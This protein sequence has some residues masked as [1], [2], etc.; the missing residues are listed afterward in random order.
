MGGGLANKVARAIQDHMLD[1][2]GWC[3]TTMS[4]QVIRAIQEAGYAIVPKELTDT[5]LMQIY[6]DEREAFKRTWWC[7][8]STAP[9]PL[10]PE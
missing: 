3:E 5:M 1:E 6:P 9:D 4:E 10:T 2:P 8:L 7:L